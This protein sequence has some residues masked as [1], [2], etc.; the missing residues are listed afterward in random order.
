MSGSDQSRTFSKSDPANGALAS[1]L[2]SVPALGADMR[3]AKVMMV[4]DEP[5]TIEVLQAFLENEGYQ[6]FIT[7][8]ESRQAIDLLTA[9][10][11][12]VVLLDLNMPEVSGFDI[13]RLA[14]SHDRFRHIPII[15]LTSSNDSETKLSALQLGASDFLAKPVDPSELALRL[16]NTLA[17][18]AYQDRL[19]YYDTL[20]GLPNRQMFI[21]RL[22][23]SLHSA[24][25]DGTTAAVLHIGIDGFHN[26]N[27][28]FGHTGGDELLAAVARRLAPCVPGV[29]DLKSDDESRALLA[30]VSGDEFY[31]LIQDMPRVEYPALVAEKI[32]DAM[33]EPFQLGGRE[34]FLTFSIGIAIFPHDGAAPETLLKHAGVALNQAKLRGRNTY[35]F[36]T[37]S[38]NAKALERLNMASQLRRAIERDELVALYQPKVDVRAGRVVGA[39]VLLRWHHPDLGAISPVEFIPLAEETGLIVPF[40]EWVLRAACKQNRLWQSMGLAPIR[41]AVNVSARQFCDEKFLLTLADA[42]HDSNLDAQWLTLEITENTMMDAAKDNLA[43]LHQI[44]AMGV[45]LSVDDFGTGYSSL[46]YLKQLPLDELKIDRSFITEIQ[47]AAD[48]APIVTAIVAMAHS[49]GLSVVIEGVETEPQLIF[50]KAQGCDEYQGYFFSKPVASDDFLALL[51][52]ASEARESDTSLHGL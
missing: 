32:L 50:A 33:K 37:T 25:R 45:K 5:T 21:D 7:T 16:R 13:L 36:F 15:V 47:S 30:R 20:T 35:Q 26:I 51:G 52:R 6:R 12:D 43:V 8:T 46:S 17:A 31:L 28:A 48:H 23:W 9:H 11:P 29:D 27:H 39:E 34:V 19:T 2:N 24:E 14:R 38:M 49:L 44:K 40:G 18:K 41:V 4:D 1:G 10:N 42:L 22:H 3:Q